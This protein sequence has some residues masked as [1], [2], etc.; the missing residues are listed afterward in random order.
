MYKKTMNSSLGNKIPLGLIHP[1]IANLEYANTTDHKKINLQQLY[2]DDRNLQMNEFPYRE[3]Q[4]KVNQK[5]RKSINQIKN[6]NKTKGGEGK[7][8]E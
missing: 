8:I 6:G 3:N 7:G 1:T 5:W 4:W 2:E